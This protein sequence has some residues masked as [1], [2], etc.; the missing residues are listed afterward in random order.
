MAADS[1]PSPASSACARALALTVSEK[2][3][4]SLSLFPTDAPPSSASKMTQVLS[5][6]R[7]A[8][9]SSFFPGGGLGATIGGS[10]PPDRGQEG[11]GSVSKRDDRFFNNRSEQIVKRNSEGGELLR[12][13]VHVGVYG[14]GSDG[15]RLVSGVDHQSFDRFNVKE[16]FG[17]VGEGG[18]LFG[19]V[20]RSVEF[21][22]LTKT[23]AFERTGPRA[24]ISG[25]VEP[26]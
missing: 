9:V 22:F 17:G 15:G 12:R 5:A 20:K 4:A 8:S 3:C 7:R 18:V 19:D 11:G 16:G 1:G 21:T 25:G 26:V 6:K 10:I 23:R 24:E 2:A 14:L 13:L